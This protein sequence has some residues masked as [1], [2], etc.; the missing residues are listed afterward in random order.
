M[1]IFLGGVQLSYKKRSVQLGLII[2]LLVNILLL[3]ELLTERTS[4]VSFEKGQVDYAFTSLVNDPK[5]LLLHAIDNAASSLDIAIYNFDDKDIAEAVIR[6]KNRGVNIRIITDAEK[7][8]KDSRAAILDELSLNQIE[9]KVDQTRKMHLKTAIIDHHLVV[10]GSYNYT[11][12]SANENL[13]QMI[14]LSNEELADEWTEIFTTLWNKNQL[15]S[16]K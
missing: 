4:S 6:A 14:T 8:E 5:T 10:T 3:N 2:S 16:W 11:E 13:E 12:A 7:S 1:K 9:V 15:K